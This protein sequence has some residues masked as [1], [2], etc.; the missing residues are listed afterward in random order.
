MMPRVLPV[1]LSP[2]ADLSLTL[3]TITN[4]YIDYREY[5]PGTLLVAPA[6][7]LD[8]HLGDLVPGVAEVIE[9]A[10]WEARRR[11]QP[12]EFTYELRERERAARV[13][14]RDQRAVLSI[15]DMTRALRYGTTR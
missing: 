1:G 2:T 10:A 4:K 5:T 3:D 13:M 9:R 7:L 8:R 15:R 11:R 12:Q 14:V 6:D